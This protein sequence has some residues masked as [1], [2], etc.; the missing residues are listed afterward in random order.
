MYTDISYQGLGAVLAQLDDEGH[1][2]VITYASRNLVGAEHNYAATEIECLASVWT[3]KYF[4]SYIYMTEFTLVTDHS[5]LQWI[6]NNPNPGQRL[7]RWILTI[8]DYPYKIQYHKGK[9][10]LNA[11]AL[12]CIPQQT[13]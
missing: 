3:I 6:M 10:H 5:A 7:S 1:E 8:S 11:D 12:S 9:K 2:H 4:C 13:T